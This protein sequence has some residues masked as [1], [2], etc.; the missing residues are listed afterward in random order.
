MPTLRL[1]C[2]EEG[3]DKDTLDLSTMLNVPVTGLPKPC[4]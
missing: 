4:S 1:L 2:D 3:K